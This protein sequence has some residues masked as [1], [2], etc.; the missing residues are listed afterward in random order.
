M[1]DIYC[2]LRHFLF[3]LF[4]AYLEYVSGFFTLSWIHLILYTM[5]IQL[6]TSFL[7]HF[8]TATTKA[9]LHWKG[10]KNGKMEDCEWGTDATTLW[11][12][13]WKIRRGNTLLAWS[14]VNINKSTATGAKRLWQPCFISLGKRQEGNQAT[15]YIW[16]KAHIN[17][18][19]MKFEKRTAGT[20]D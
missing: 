18:K 8:T 14:F 15:M 16:V 10:K 11:S 13:L 5:P 9:R 1:T 4:P 6:L 17:S 20:L 2:M 12:V 7:F 19:M 3:K